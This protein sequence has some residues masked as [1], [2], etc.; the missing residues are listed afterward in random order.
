VDFS[1]LLEDRN[2]AIEIA[3]VSTHWEP[4][5]ALVARG[6]RA[7]A[8]TDVLAL[9]SL[10]TTQNAILAYIPLLALTE[11]DPGTADRNAVSACLDVMARSDPRIVANAYAACLLHC[12]RR[13]DFDFAQELHAR[14]RT[15]FP[16]AKPNPAVLLALALCHIKRSE[17]DQAHT[18]FAAIVR[19][20]PATEEAP[21]A[22]LLLGWID[23][24][25][26]KY[27]EARVTLE[28]LVRSYPA[29]PCAD[30]ARQILLQMPEAAE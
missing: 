5:T 15:R 16:A 11:T 27:P 17:L 14:Y 13:G 20:F 4:V 9:A 19:D 8:R 18:H 10:M 26:Q 21:R 7:Q 23:L 12:Y 6:E 28:A 24:S 25:R 3:I 22:A 2:A 30:K 1:L 29:N